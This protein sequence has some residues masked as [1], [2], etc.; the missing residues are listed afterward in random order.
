MR[1]SVAA[2]L[3]IVCLMAAPA[4]AGVDPLLASRPSVRAYTER[5]GLPQGTIHAIAFDGQGFLW[6]GTQDGAARF[7]G[8]AWVRFDMPDRAVS[9]FVRAVLPARDGSLWFGREEGGLVR[10]REGEAKV[11]GRN[12]G[13]PAGRVN[14]LLEASDGRIWAATHG[15]GVARFTGTVFE[16]VADGLPDLRVWQ[17][18]EGRN[19][20]GA[21]RLLAACEG[22][23]V[24]LRDARRWVAFDLGTPLA[25]VSVN[26]LLETGEGAE[27][28]L[29]AGTFG[30]GLFRVRGGRVTRFGPGNGLSSRLVTSLAVTPGAGGDAVVWVGTRDAGVFRLN[31]GSFEHVL[32]GAPTNGIYTLAGGVGVDAETLWVGTR[33]SG[34]LRV[35][36]ATWA[37]LDSASGL[38]GD[39][40]FCFLEEKRP[41]GPGA[42][43][44]GTNKGAAV[45]S[46][47]QVETHGIEKGLPDSQVRSMAS[48]RKE[49]GGRDIWASVIG[50]G[51]FRFDGRRWSAVDAGRAFR[52]VDAAVLLAVDDGESP[53]ELWVGTEKSGL[54]RLVGGRWNAYGLAEGLPSNSVLSLLSTRGEAGRSVWVGT[55]GGGLAE[56]VGGRVVAVH[57]RGSGLPNN[58]VLSLAEVGRPDGRREL[59][60]G[61]RGGV[62][63]RLLDVPGSSWSLLSVETSPSLPNDSVFLVAPGRDGRVYLGTNRGVAR[64]SLAADG[65]SFGE[66]LT[67]GTNEGLPSAA[68]N[69]GSLVDSEGRIWVATNAGAAVLD[70]SR[71]EGTP[72]RPHPL[73]IERFAV[74]GVEKPPRDELRLAPK[75]RDVAFE[76]ALLAFHG[77][78]LVRYRSQLVGWEASPSEWV[79]THR[80]EFTN[81]PPGRYTFRVWGRDA[82]A[83]VSGPVDVGFEVTQS[84]WR[85]PAALLLWALLA[86]ALGLVALRVREKT[87]HRRAEELEALVKLRTLELS[88]ARDAAEAATESKSRFLAHMAHEVRTPLNAILGYSDLLAEEMRDRGADD[89]LV[90]LEKIRRAAGHQLALVTEALDLGKIEAGKAELHLTSFDAAR[91]VRE[92]AEIAWPLVKKGHNRLE[93][94]GVEAL[95]TVFSD[96]G[97]LRQVLLNLLSNAARFTEKGTI[98]IEAAHVDDTLT[99]RVRDTGVGM[100]PEQLERVFT[101]YAQA[102]AGTSAVYGGTGLGLV[103][104][105]GYCELLRGSLDVASAPGKGSTFTVKL[106]VRLE[107]RSGAR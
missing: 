53:A 26:S 65:A 25:G 96:E 49:G 91:L 79:P 21:T 52:T 58:N 97:K 80:R 45:L 73:V 8:R 9:N 13:L 16:P 15:G 93:T 47:G 84:W 22:G 100:S 31:E 42:I 46:D 77:E 38:P 35:Q 33:V 102:G 85:Q 92:A 17:L 39:Q 106:P 99:I 48:L 11:F 27:R 40:V 5:D 3:A 14:H 105:R 24:E 94:R 67:F 4:S 32:L 81:L 2:A 62:A 30:S 6:V 82:N 86:A 75:E 55:R 10:V 18:L 61:T 7:N 71:K 74:S 23:V 98:S 28:T 87:L 44:V 29:W 51:L 107:R 83:S 78:S 50:Y 19:R 88:E 90:D 103:I 72:R 56:I 95:G 34:L 69:Q 101:P 20:E 1:A 59:W 60:A 41:A 37:A 54:G 64:V 43:W 89:L 68:C 66:A 70:P 12:E 76:F 57:D 104:S 36:D 63:R